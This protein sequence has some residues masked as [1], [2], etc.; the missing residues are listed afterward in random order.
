LEELI[1]AKDAAID[2][3]EQ[4]AL[5]GLANEDALEEGTNVP[6]NVFC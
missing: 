3:M 5:E 6:F 2:E 1:K 4:E